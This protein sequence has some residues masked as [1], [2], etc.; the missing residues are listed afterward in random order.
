MIRR[1]RSW[2]GADPLQLLALV[3]SFALTGYA[4]ERLLAAEA[5]SVA[6]W[7]VGA[8]V[9]H[10]LLLF[11]LYALADRAAGRFA[12]GAAVPWINHLRF[13]AVISGVLL[14][15][16]WPTIVRDPVAFDVA[17]GRT[18]DPYSGRWL[19]ITGVLFAA[20]A[21][22]YAVRVRFRGKSTL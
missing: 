8:V 5:K 9:A 7:F 4:A 10:D 15:V 3:A 11:P 19:A 2:Y 21:L 20:S 13:P 1:L 6:I 18:D 16:W 22:V 14:L 17:S 12:R